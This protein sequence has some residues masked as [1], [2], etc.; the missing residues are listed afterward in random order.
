VRVM[1]KRTNR[2]ALKAWCSKCH[3]SIW[4]NDEVVFEKGVAHKN[5]RAA[6]ADGTKRKQ[7]P[8]FKMT[9]GLKTVVLEEFARKLKEIREF[10]ESE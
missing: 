2:E 5:C 4:K 1:H 9:Y 3:H 7:H 8:N 6:L 10:K